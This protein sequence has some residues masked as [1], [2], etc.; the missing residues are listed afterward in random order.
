MDS[1]LYEI[2]E[3]RATKFNMIDAEISLENILFK[4]GCIDAEIDE[5]RGKIEIVTKWKVRK[6]RD[7]IL[8]YIPYK[9][10]SNSINN[11]SKEIISDYIN[12]V[13]VDDITYY[14][15]LCELLH[16]KGY[17]WSNSELLFPINNNYISINNILLINNNRITYCTDEPTK[18]SN[19]SCSKKQFCKNPIKISNIYNKDKDKIQS[20]K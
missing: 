17:I 5:S 19:I 2:Q 1:E 18:C 20:Y 3:K 9:F 7:P 11:N 13:L 10:I 15:W 14:P 4:E 12:A 6:E 16:N 8:G